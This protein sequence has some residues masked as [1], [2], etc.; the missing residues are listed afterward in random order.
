[1]HPFTLSIRIQ[2]LALFGFGAHK[3]AFPS[4]PEHIRV[5][6]SRFPSELEVPGG[7]SEGNIAVE[8]HA[9]RA[10]DISAPGL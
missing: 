2:A 9:L 8:A 5:Q 7:C 1:M 3:R 4:L 6:K 10:G